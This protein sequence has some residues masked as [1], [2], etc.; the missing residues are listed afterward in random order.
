MTYDVSTTSNDGKRR[1]RNVARIMEA[2]G[3]RVQKSVFECILSPEQLLLLQ[4]DLLQAI[5]ANEDSIRIYRLRSP[6]HQHTNLIGHQPT[7]DIRD[8]LL[9]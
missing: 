1:L 2:Y 3:Q 8:P 4:H 6:H 5:D 7:F 9:A